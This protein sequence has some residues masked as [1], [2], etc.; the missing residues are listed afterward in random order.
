M[1]LQACQD[2]ADKPTHDSARRHVPPLE[3]RI[4][5]Y[6]R[7]KLL[8]SRRMSYSEIAETL[9]KESGYRPSKGQL[10]GWLRGIHG[11]FGSA[12]RFDSEPT[13]ELAYV[14][15][16]KFGDG[17]IS[18]KGYNRSIRLQSVDLE[19]VFEFDRCLSIVLGTRRHKPWF[20]TKR[21]EIQVEARSVLL[22][23]FLRQ[24]W[25]DLKSWIEH[26]SKCVSMFLRGFFDS[27]GSIS[28]EGYVKAYNSDVDL[29]KYVQNLL[30]LYFEIDSTGPHLCIR[31]GTK[32]SRRGHIYFRRRDCY[33]IYVR[34][35]SLANFHE[36]VGFVIQRKKVR[37]LAKLEARVE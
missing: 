36:A 32:I 34:A 18:R 35:R 19:F 21:R 16:V 2:S 12:N 14:I 31:A 17:S 9:E 25:K 10:S 4:K 28:R 11:P 20:D 13:P 26:C 6:D 7:A 3:V 15:G 5:S 24:S 1:R 29:L 23:N 27:E 33:S 8:R 37:L 30:S 22:Y